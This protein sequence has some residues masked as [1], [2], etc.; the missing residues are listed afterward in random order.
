M[1]IMMIVFWALITVAVVV[2]FAG[3]SG[4]ERRLNRWKPFLL[5][6]YVFWTSTH[7]LQT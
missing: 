4:R 2:A 6:V 7:N 1:T 5:I 3:W